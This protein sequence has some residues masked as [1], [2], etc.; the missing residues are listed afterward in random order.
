[1]DNFD[2]LQRYQAI[3]LMKKVNVRTDTSERQRGVLAL[4]LLAVVYGI[5][6]LIPRYLSTSFLLFQQVYLRIFVG[7]ILSFVFFRK[8]I[9]FEKLKKLPLKEW[10]LLALRAFSYYLLGVVLYTQALLLTKIANV[11]FIGAIPMTAILGF[12]ILKERL[13]FEKISLVF[14]S[15][16]GVLAISAQ[17]FSNIFVFGKGEIVALLSIFFVSLGFISRKWQSKTLN[18]R[19]IATFMLFFA[20]VFIFLASI[21]K[22][23]G[24]PLYNWHLGIVL[25]LLLAGLLN[26]GVSFLMNYG[27]SRI[28]AVLGSNIIALDPVFAT[29]FAFLVFRE[30]PIPKEL[31]GGALIISSAILMNRDLVE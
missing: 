4:L 1:M 12:I 16:L 21:L 10:G 14:L 27:F 26:V 29:F 7:F 6:P 22:G 25:A 8:S 23:E 30:L 28:N 15:F 20:F 18:D 31:F 9:D 2:F 13:T 11:A 19:E 24:L 3:N 5:L 17:D